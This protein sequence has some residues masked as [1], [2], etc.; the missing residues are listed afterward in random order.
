MNTRYKEGTVLKNRLKL[1][2]IPVWN[3]LDLQRAFSPMELYDQ[4]QEY[5]MFAK[6][7]CCLLVSKLENA[8]HIRYEAEYLTK[9]FWL[10]ILLNEQWPPTADPEECLQFFL[11]KR[12]EELSEGVTRED[13]R[14]E[15]KAEALQ[16]VSDA[17]IIEKLSYI[18][19]NGTIEDARQGVLL[20]AIC[21]IAEMDAREQRFA[22]RSAQAVAV[23]TGP[24][25][26]WNQDVIELVADGTVYRFFYHDEESLQPQAQIRTVLFKALTGN[27]RYDRVVIE[28]YSERKGCCVETVQLKGGE[29]RHCNASNGRIIKFLPDISVENGC[30]L[31]RKRLSSPEITV[32]NSHR[33]HSF[34]QDD[35]TGFVAVGAREGILLVCSGKLNLGKCKASSDNQTE[36]KLI[37]T[38]A[39]LDTLD[40]VEIG[41]VESSVKIL[42]TEGCVY[43][44]LC[45]EDGVCKWTPVSIRHPEQTDRISLSAATRAPELSVN[46]KDAVQAAMSCDRTQAAI[47][48]QD[49]RCEIL[50]EGSF[51][52]LPDQNQLIVGGSV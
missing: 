4:L 51:S 2:D 41:W 33:T 46:R 24:E 30:T 28:L 18:C 45:L 3:L 43:S 21:E 42:T 47:L 29:Y 52:Y 32:T 39:A 11:T 49:G 9:E 8:E 37:A 5:V 12:W 16:E 7:H 48:L 36:L 26:L 50:P 22:P 44:V 14:Q 38:R 17:Q 23:Q 10:D 35:V 34:T 31:Y 25:L 13:E 15:L 1:N 40:V 20:L 6:I 19:R 27:N